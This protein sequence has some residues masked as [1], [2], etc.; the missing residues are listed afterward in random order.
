MLIFVSML[1]WQMN[2]QKLIKCIQ[3]E[4]DDREGNQKKEI[5]KA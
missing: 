4:V 3:K 2:F 5:H 1:F